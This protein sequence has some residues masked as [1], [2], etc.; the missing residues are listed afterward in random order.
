MFKK[1]LLTALV[2]TSFSIMAADKEL[3]ITNFYRMDNQNFRDP[4]HDVCFKV[5]P[6][7]ADGKHY[8]AT[9]IAD[10]GYRSQGVY[11]T[12]VGSEGSACVVISSFRGLVEVKV[13]KLK[14]DTKKSL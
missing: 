3:K 7:P 4:A 2:M 5:T 1:L 10:K 11:Q 6:A 14:L 9:V 8:H 13:P 12:L